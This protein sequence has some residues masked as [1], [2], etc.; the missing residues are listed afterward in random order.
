MY[1]YIDRYRYIVIFYNVY[2]YIMVYI[3]V[4][5]NVFGPDFFIKNCNARQIKNEEGWLVPP[6]L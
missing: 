1:Y 5:F 2:Y 6:L 3:M 4:V